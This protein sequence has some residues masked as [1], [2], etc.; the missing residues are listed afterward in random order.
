MCTMIFFEVMPSYVIMLTAHHSVHHKIPRP[1]SNLHIVSL[2][3]VGS[4]KNN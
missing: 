1:M 3:R 4:T 2:L